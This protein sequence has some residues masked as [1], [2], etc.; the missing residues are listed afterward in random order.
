VRGWAPLLTSLSCRFEFSPEIHTPF[1]GRARW[2]RHTYRTADDTSRHFANCARSCV[3]TARQA[4]TA[5]RWRG[6]RDEGGQTSTTYLEFLQRPHDAV[7]PPSCPLKI[8][9]HCSRCSSMGVPVVNRKNRS[10]RPIGVSRT[11]ASAMR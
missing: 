1:D 11:R 5:D 3:S 7:V 9:D 8:C 6:V 10:S 2:G 4:F